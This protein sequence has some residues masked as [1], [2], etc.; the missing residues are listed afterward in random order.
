MKSDVWK[1][2]KDLQCL[3]KLK[4][5]NEWASLAND[6]F[7]SLQ[8]SCKDWTSLEKWSKNV[9]CL[10]N[11]NSGF[12]HYLILVKV[13]VLDGIVYFIIG[14]VCKLFCL[15]WCTFNFQ[16]L[17]SL[18]HGLFNQ[19][20]E[21]G[22]FVFNPKDPRLLSLIHGLFNQLYELGQFVFNPKDPR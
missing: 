12:F 10:C 2:W 4:K 18:I 9:S 14:S 8:V 16:I 13:S 22:Q 19:L 21:L 17:L 3:D 7:F 1:P 20:Y 6:C 11:R 15:C 5:R